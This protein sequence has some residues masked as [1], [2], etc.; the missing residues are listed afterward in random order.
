MMGP[1]AMVDRSATVGFVIAVVALLGC[2]HPPSPPKRASG[3]P[4]DAT[5]AGGVDGG[6]WAVCNLTPLGVLCTIYNENTGEVWAR[7]HFRDVRGAP[8][9]ASEIVFDGY[10]GELVR[11]KDGRT[12]A[13]TPGWSTHWKE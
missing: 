5:W 1:V 10:D 2:R 13:P 8:V 7:G 11:L 3:V 9:V 6:S 4:P 12:L